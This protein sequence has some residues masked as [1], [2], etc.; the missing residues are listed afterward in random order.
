MSKALDQA[1]QVVVIGLGIGL[2]YGGY[3]LYKGLQAAAGSLGPGGL[4]LPGSRDYL[5]PSGAK[6]HDEVGPLGVVTTCEPPPPPAENAKK[7]RAEQIAWGFDNANGK[8][9]LAALNLP[10]SDP[11][12]EN[13]AL[14]GGAERYNSVAR[15]HAEQTDDDVAWYDVMAWWGAHRAAEGSGVA[16][17]AQNKDYATLADYATGAFHWGAGSPPRAVATTGAP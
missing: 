4:H 1:E 2:L 9:T 8:A 16:V 10:G 11:E 14:L 5:S 7:S 6:C 13:T 15:K 12:I 3:R 17:A